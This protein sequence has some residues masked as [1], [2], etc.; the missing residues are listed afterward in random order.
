M[1]LFWIQLTA[2]LHLVTFFPPFCGTV[3]GHDGKLVFGL[4]GGKPVVLMRGR[5]HYYEGHPMWRVSDIFWV[6]VC[7]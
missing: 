1:Q 4:L 2:A 7:M 6:W 3:P 5:I